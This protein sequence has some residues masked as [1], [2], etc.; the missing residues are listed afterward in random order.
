MQEEKEKGF[1]FCFIKRKTDG[2]KEKE[3]DSPLPVA[4]LLQKKK[5]KD[6]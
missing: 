5:R 1:F 4:D 6:K 3:K 2:A